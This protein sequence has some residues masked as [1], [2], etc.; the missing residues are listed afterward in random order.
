MGERSQRGR[1]GGGWD[2]VFY[3]VFVHEMGASIC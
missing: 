2:K 3:S 1:E